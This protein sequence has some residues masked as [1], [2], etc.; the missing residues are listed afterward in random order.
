MTTKDDLMK[1]YSLT[2]K[3]TEELFARL[4]KFASTMLEKF[5]KI[6]SD[7]KR[8]AQYNREG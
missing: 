6:A 8:I 2:E 5:K 4:E 3:E 1:R 7:F